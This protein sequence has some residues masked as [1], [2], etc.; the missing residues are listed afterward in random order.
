MKQVYVISV[1]SFLFVS[2]TCHVKDECLFR[3]DSIE[4]KKTVLSEL[5]DSVEYIPLETMDVSLFPASMLA[6]TSV[7]G[8]VV[9]AEDNP[10]IIKYQLK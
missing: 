3:V 8:K 5:I 9:D 4:D 1:L 10:V 6:G 7:N 2:C